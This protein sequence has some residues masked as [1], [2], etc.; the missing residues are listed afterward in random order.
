MV[1]YISADGQRI[2]DLE[3]RCHQEK[4]DKLEEE[5]RIRK[6]IENEHLYSKEVVTVEHYAYCWF[7]AIKQRS[8]IEYHRAKLAQSEKLLADET[9]LIQADYESNPDTD[10]KWLPF[11]KSRL[12]SRGEDNLYNSLVTGYLNLR[13]E[14]LPDTEA[15]P[16]PAS[17]KGGPIP[18]AKKGGPSD[19]GS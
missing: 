15:P 7:R 12:E 16:I 18:A 14:I 17:E 1:K 4:V 5:V 3:D 8:L 13:N 11:I 10:R 19:K 6:E 2:E 9:A